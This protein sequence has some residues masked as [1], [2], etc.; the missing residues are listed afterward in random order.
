MTTSATPETAAAGPPLAS[1]HGHAEAAL[2]SKEELG[3]YP[4]AQR[5]LRRLRAGVREEQ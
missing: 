2:A 4:A 1:S 5:R 3:A